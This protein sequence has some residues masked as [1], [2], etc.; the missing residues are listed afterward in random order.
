MLV[1]SVSFRDDVIVWTRFQ[2]LKQVFRGLLLLQTKSFGSVWLP[3]RGAPSCVGEI[4]SPP[5]RQFLQSKAGLL[6]LEMQVWAKPSSKQIFFPLS[7]SLSVLRLFY[8]P[9]T[10]I[11]WKVLWLKSSHVSKTCSWCTCWCGSSNRKNAVAYTSFQAMSSSSLGKY[12]A[13]NHSCNLS[14]L[15]LQVSGSFFRTCLLLVSCLVLNC[16]VA[17]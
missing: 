13:H 6:P 12:I 1:L 11:N 7:L 4:T 10:K 8:T 16:P 17:T 15:R 2:L 5:S 14:H 3:N 9:K